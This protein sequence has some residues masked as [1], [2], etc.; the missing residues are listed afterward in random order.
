MTQ[1]PVHVSIDVCAA[2][3]RPVSV[4]QLKR[5]DKKEWLFCQCETFSSLDRIAQV[6]DE[7]FVNKCWINKRNAWRRQ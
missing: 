4:A 5:L 1:R 6:E 2:A 7:I 3:W